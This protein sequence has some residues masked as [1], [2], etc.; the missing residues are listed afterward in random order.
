MPDPNAPAETSP[1]ES[2]EA[3]L[4]DAL[5]EGEGWQFEPKWDGFRCL[6]FKEAGAV[7]L[8]AKSGK[9]LH[10][11][12]PE[13]AAA[14]AAIAALMSGIACT[15][16]RLDRRPLA[17]SALTAS[18]IALAAFQAGYSYVSAAWNPGTR[19][20]DVDLSRGFHS[21]RRQ[22][23]LDF[24]R[25]GI[26]QIVARLHNSDHVHRVI[27]YLPSDILGFE[28]PFAFE[29]RDPHARPPHERSRLQHS[30]AV[31]LGWNKP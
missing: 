28:L 6:A 2:M 3:L 21:Y 14:I 4:V 26:S 13:V 12:F 31:G 5:P 8:F 18:A 20:F 10:R 23:Q 15:F 25:A 19:A 24:E 9:P 29:E 16:G 1:I 11:F 22:R 30:G 17:M 7:R 27:G